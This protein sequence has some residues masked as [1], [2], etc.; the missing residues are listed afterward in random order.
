M[1][2]DLEIEGLVENIV[3]RGNGQEIAGY[4]LIGFFA[5][6]SDL[7]LTNMCLNLDPTLN[8]SA[9]FH[10]IAQLRQSVIARAEYAGE[11]MLL[12]AIKSPPHRALAVVS[13]LNSDLERELSDMTA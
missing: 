11:T 6:H 8:Q 10:G 3:T 7:A 5:D 12:D 13:D 9:L 2:S 4:M 1:Y